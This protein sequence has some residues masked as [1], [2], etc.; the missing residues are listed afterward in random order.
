MAEATGQVVTGKVT[1]DP[2]ARKARL[3]PD[4]ALLPLAAYRAT[5]TAG[6]KDRVGNAMP[7]DHVWS[8]QTTANIRGPGAAGRPRAG[9]RPGPVAAVPPPPPPIDP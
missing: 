7:G 2:A 1:Y 5:V 6:V 9:P 8:F 3:R 4:K